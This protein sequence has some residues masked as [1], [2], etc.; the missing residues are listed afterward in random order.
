MGLHVAIDV[1]IRSGGHVGGVEQFV[2]GLVSG[3][4]ERDDDIEYT[5]VTHPGDPDW[6]SPYVGDEIT[7]VPRP[8]SG[9]V[10]RVRWALGP[11]A[12]VV[13]PVVKP[14]IEAA[15]SQSAGGVG[16]A[17][18]FFESLGVDLVHFPTQRYLNSELPTVYN[19]HDLQHRHYPENFSD[20]QLA[21]RRET[22]RS[23]C[24]GSA[25]V[26]V[27]SSF[28]KQDVV[29]AF[30]VTA[31]DVYAIPRGPPIDVYESN[32]QVA[33]TET[34]ERFGLP[35]RFVFYPAQP[36][37]HKN[38]ETLIEALALARDDLDCEISLVCTGKRTAHWERVERRIV[39]LGLTD[40]VQYLGYVSPAHLRNLYSLATFVVFP[41]RFEGGGFPLLEAWSESTAVTCSNV[42]ALPE[43]AGDCARLFDPTEPV[44]IAQSLR[45]LSRDTTF[46]NDLARC[47]VD[48]VSAFSWNKT[49]ATYS[50]LYKKVA[51]EE[52]TA[53]EQERLEAARAGEIP[54]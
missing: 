24:E 49:A 43:K 45:E 3:L 25:A 46:R 40:L 18:G 17:E 5:V 30:D 31:K 6:L 54:T 13:E 41:S 14:V 21:N 53:S 19:P 22:Y 20:R 27:P 32:T 11:I 52:L 39:D 4:S 2:L 38:H 36:W 47:G 7:F 10:E 44:E 9:P 33:V 1:P 12:D 42:T 28:T 16:D 51:G 48:R 23:G 34:R 8:W 29:D 37:P 50:A 35:E 15:R 26:D